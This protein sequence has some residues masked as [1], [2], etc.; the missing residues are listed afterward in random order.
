MSRPLISFVGRRWKR[1]YFALQRHNLVLS[2]HILLIGDEETPEL[3]IEG[4][5]LLEK[6]LLLLRRTAE[7][8]LYVFRVDV[9]Q[10]REAYCEVAERTSEFRIVLHKTD[11]QKHQGSFRLATPAEGTLIRALTDCG[12][13]GLPI[14]RSAFVL[15]AWGETM[16]TDDQKE[17][18]YEAI[19][20]AVDEIVSE[21]VQQHYE[22]LT[23]EPQL[24]SRIAGAIEMTMRKFDV[25]DLHIEIEVRDFPSI[26][27][28][29]LERKVGADIYISV[30]VIPEN[31]RDRSKGMLAQAKWD[32]TVTDP[33]LPEQIDKMMARAPAASY[34]WVYGPDGVTSYPA[35]EY[36]HSIAT[37]GGRSVGSLIAN[38]LRC[39]EGDYGIGRDL[40][41]PLITSLN[42][43]M[44]VL[45]VDTAL[46]F[47]IREGSRRNRIYRRR[48]GKRVK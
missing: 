10:N 47:T 18:V 5:V 33:H 44:E 37:G 29:S 2:I 20:N 16:A 11:N 19:G 8:L 21:V 7:P 31:R 25:G 40:T 3:L 27:P 36:L 22:A 28:G 46:S 39:N 34:V 9:D 45:G 14:P 26:G 13:W 1:Q 38:G 4:R 12:L 35:G 41:K 48:R 43:A 6:L 23:Q 15:A 42:E 30:A 24:T 32:D 17:Q